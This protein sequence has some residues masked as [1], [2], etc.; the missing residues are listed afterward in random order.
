MKLIAKKGLKKGFRNLQKILD[1]TRY[2]PFYP[3]PT[4]KGNMEY[5][6]ALF[7][8]TKDDWE[9]YKDKE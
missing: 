8:N 2:K 3:L 5:Q 6:Q 7:S 4:D 9:D 1:K